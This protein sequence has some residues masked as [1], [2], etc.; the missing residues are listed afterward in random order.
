MSL[1][2]LARYGT[3][4]EADHDRQILWESEIDAVLLD[5]ETEGFFTSSEHHSVRLMVS[6]DDADRAAD[7]LAAT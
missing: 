1:V 7:I 5:L 3:R 2:E 4:A 6:E